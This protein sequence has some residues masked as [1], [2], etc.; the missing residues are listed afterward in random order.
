MSSPAVQTKMRKYEYNYG[1]KT[2]YARLLLQVHHVM[3][4]TMQN[5]QNQQGAEE[6]QN[7]LQNVKDTARIL[8]EEKENSGLK[9]SKVAHRRW[10]ELVDVGLAQWYK[11]FVNE[12]IEKNNAN[13]KLKGLAPMDGYLFRREHREYNNQIDEL[14]D[15]VAEEEL[16]SVVDVMSNRLSKQ[17]NTRIEISPGARGSVQAPAIGNEI[18]Q[19][20]LEGLQKR[21]KEQ[22]GEYQLGDGSIRKAT[23]SKGDL[24]IS[25]QVTGEI[26]DTPFRKIIPYLQKSQ[27]TVKNYKQWTFKEWGLGLGKSNL[28][29]AIT[30]ELDR[31]FPN[32]KA[33][34]QRDIFYRGVQIITKTNQTPSASPTQVEKHFSHMRFIYELTGYGLIGENGEVQF[35]DYLIFNEP[36]SPNIYVRDT[37]SL[38]LDEIERR[39][40]TVKLYEGIHLK[41]I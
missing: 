22:N 6:L 34:I 33:S 23:R 37:A 19:G 3:V 31:V 35:A 25:I 18:H 8:E 28:Y 2:G 29:K 5:K 27:W 24:N 21:A 30:T 10:D 36:D 16:Y 9:K 17:K 38:I 13:R 39:N 1:G 15:D 4:G 40:S 26:D 11:D 12:I 14:F 41:N 7:F 20:L 32:N